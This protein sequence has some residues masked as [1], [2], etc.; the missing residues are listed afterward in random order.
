MDLW[1]GVGAAVVNPVSGDGAWFLCNDKLEPARTAA[2]PA[3]RSTSAHRRA[4]KPSPFALVS[5]SSAGVLVA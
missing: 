5:S 2:S 1:G 4:K 3:A